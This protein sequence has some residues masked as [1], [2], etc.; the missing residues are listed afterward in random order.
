LRFSGRGQFSPDSRLLAVE[1]GK[2]V[3][4]LIDIASGHDLAQL[5]D[6]R[7]DGALYHLFSPDGTR[8]VTLGKG[9]EG[10]IH[11]WDLR[12]LRAELKELG[13]DWDP[14]EYAPAPTAPKLPLRL[15]IDMGN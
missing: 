14:P 13:L 8:L 2:G 11:V 10:G 3:I 1:T 7:Q 6:P 9:R 5:E 12:A 4:R 15:E